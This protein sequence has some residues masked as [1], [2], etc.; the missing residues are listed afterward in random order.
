MVFPG[1]ADSGSLFLKPAGSLEAWDAATGEPRW[2]I[3]RFASGPR[4]SLDTSLIAAVGGICYIG[5]AEIV[6][7]PDGRLVEGPDGSDLTK[8]S[9]NAFAADSGKVRWRLPI[10]PGPDLGAPLVAVPGTVF[11]GGTT[12]MVR[13]VSEV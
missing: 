11:L 9:L 12:A 7:G 6:Y 2:A 13:A 3:D 8:Y 4:W 1:T 5:G 10:D